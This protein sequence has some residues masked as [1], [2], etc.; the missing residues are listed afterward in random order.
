MYGGYSQASPSTYQTTCPGQCSSLCAP[1]CRDPCCRFPPSM[2]NSAPV[3]A[4]GSY[5]QGLVNSYPPMTTL[6]A[7]QSSQNYQ[8]QQPS[9]Q[10]SSQCSP[11]SCSPSCSPSC[12]SSGAQGTSMVP[13]GQINAGCPVSCFSN[14]DMSCPRRCCV[15][16]R[17]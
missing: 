7:S 3:P 13:P 4:R 17:K 1:A 6:G 8:Q 15:P 5:Q 11:Q 12:C 9:Q 14:C 2:Y 16:G 10:C